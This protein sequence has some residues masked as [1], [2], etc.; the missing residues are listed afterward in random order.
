[1]SSDHNKRIRFFIIIFLINISFLGMALCA[2]VQFLFY[3]DNREM[4]NN[5]FWPAF[6]IVAISIFMFALLVLFP[7]EIFIFSRKKRKGEKLLK[8]TFGDLLGLPFGVANPDAEVSPWIKYPVL[9]FLFLLL[10]IFAIAV[11][12]LSITYLI[13]LFQG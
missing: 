11:L 9:F 10:G 2:S 3:D 8:I 4:M 6:I 13:K 12:G 1:M 5:S 7:V